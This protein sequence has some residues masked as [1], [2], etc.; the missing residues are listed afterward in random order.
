MKCNCHELVP[1]CVDIVPIFN[2]LTKTEKQEILN[3]A[4]HKAYEKNDLVY[5]A[6][7]ID[8]KLYIVH[9]GKIKISRVSVD[10]KEQVIRILGPGEFMGELSLFSSNP[11]SDYAVAIEKTS[12]C[13]IEG[14][15][16][17]RYIEKHPE[18]AFKIIE[19]LSK[20]LEIVEELV[21]GIN[22]HSVEWRLAQ[23]LLKRA[24]KYNVVHLNTTK[25]YFASQM[26]MSQ[27]TLSR[28]LSLFQ[29][30]KWIKLVTP[31]KIAI[32]NKRALEEIL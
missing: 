23:V 12:I 24:D 21:E 10:G 27:E 25:G 31:K 17:K 14:H 22:L 7:E 16:L 8:E 11:M 13:I 28:K 3:L 32:L 18:I 6:G 20:R 26:G 1:E 2:T 4:I 29:E 5:S 9:V 30:K 19:E 15:N